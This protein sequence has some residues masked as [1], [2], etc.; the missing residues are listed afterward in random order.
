M[1]LW[2]HVGTGYVRHSPATAGGRQYP[3]LDVV[4]HGY[5]RVAVNIALVAVLFF[6]FALGALAAGKRLRGVRAS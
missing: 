4:A 2:A 5:A 1:V 6:V 3:F